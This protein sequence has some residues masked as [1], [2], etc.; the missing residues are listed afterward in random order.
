M[1]PEQPT[2]ATA[3]EINMT[4]ALTRSL[5]DIYIPGR[6]NAA[7]TSP[8]AN[9]LWPPI[10]RRDGSLP[11]FAHRVTVF[12]STLNSIAT[13][14]GSNSSS[15]SRV[16]RSFGVSWNIL[17]L[18]TLSCQIPGQTLLP[19]QDIGDVHA[20]GAYLP[21]QREDQLVKGRSGVPRIRF[22]NAQ[23]FFGGDRP[24]FRFTDYRT[25]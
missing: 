21:G 8:T 5:G 18:P 17:V 19:I 16:S 2:T 13:S 12:G 3:T 24:R 25:G 6:F 15:G 7:S 11:A 10:V 23:F 1:M 4:A 20:R 22:A 9:L 14:I